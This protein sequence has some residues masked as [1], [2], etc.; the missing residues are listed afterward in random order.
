MIE[1][2]WNCLQVVGFALWF[3]VTLIVVTASTSTHRACMPT[4]ACGTMSTL[5]QTGTN[6]SD[7]P[8]TIPTTRLCIQ[9][10][11][12]FLNNT[13][14]HEVPNKLSHTTERLT[15]C[16]LRCNALWSCLGGAVQLHVNTV[17]IPSRLLG[18]LGAWPPPLP[19]FRLFRTWP[20]KPHLPFLY[21]SIVRQWLRDSLQQQCYRV[22]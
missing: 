5:L 13:S 7:E 8:R 19:R 11:L 20:A 6:L 4:H 21:Y 9:L 17:G 10:T 12:S 22:P 16:I 14:I 3:A 15:T 18:L 2:S 1:L